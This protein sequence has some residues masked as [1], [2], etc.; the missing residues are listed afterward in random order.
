MNFWFQKNWK[1]FSVPPRMVHKSTNPRYVEEWTP[2]P[3]EAWGHEDFNSLSLGNWSLSFLHTERGNSDICHLQRPLSKRQS[4]VF[5]TP[6][7]SLYS[8]QN[9]G[10][11]GEPL[12]LNLSY[13]STGKLLKMWNNYYPFIGIAIDN[14]SDSLC[15]STFFWI[16]G[17]WLD[18]P[19]LRLP[20]EVLSP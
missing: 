16:P 5:L 11:P 17:F 4:R 10:Y 15:C 13:F 12:F 1:I 19:S 18:P 14:I 9:D 7:P 2:Y 6:A 8:N 3:V 20:P